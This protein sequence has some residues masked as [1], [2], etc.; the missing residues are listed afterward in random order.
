MSVNVYHGEESA[1]A[2]AILS[3]EDQMETQASQT[4]VLVPIQIDIDVDTFK[5]RDAF[6]WNLNGASPI[7]SCR[8]SD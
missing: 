1:D 2:R 8:T 3:S 4:A 5:I 6:V 7:S